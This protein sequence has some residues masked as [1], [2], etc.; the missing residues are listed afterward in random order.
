LELTEWLLKVRDALAEQD[1]GRRN[2]MLR[3]ADKFLKASKQ[4]SRAFHRARFGE[5]RRGN[6]PAQ[7]VHPKQAFEP[8]ARN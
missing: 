2:S 1:E 6:S 4:Q 5:C 3:T 7:V 8:Q